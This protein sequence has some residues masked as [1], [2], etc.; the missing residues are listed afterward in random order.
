MA[1][2]GAQRW[3]VRRL[4]THIS[5]LPRDSA[6]VRHL[7][8]EGAYWDEQVELTAQVVDAIERTNYYLLKVN[9]N[10][11]DAPNAVPRPGHAVNP[12]TVSLGDFVTSLKEEL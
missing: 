1:C 3:G 9:G 4:L 8:G 12:P 11:V 6:Y 7:S 5:H 10:Q 2:W